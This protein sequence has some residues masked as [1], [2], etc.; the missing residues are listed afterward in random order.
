VKSRST[1]RYRVF[2]SNAAGAR[3]IE[4]RERDGALS[5]AVVYALRGCREVSNACDESLSGS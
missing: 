2:A 5:T 3:R 4:H 1:Y